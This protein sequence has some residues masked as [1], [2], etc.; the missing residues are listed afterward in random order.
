M[1]I[2]DRTNHHTT[3]IQEMFTRIAPRYDLIN[4]LMT[5]G[6]DQAWRKE[7]IRRADLPARGMLLDVGAGTGD[8]VRQAARQYA[9]CWPLAADL[10]LEMMRIGRERALASHENRIAW[11][12]VNAENLPLP[13]ASFDAVVSG[14][15]LRNVTH[16]DAALREQYRVLKPGGRLV[17]LDTTPPALSILTPLIRFHMHT[18]IPTLGRWLTGQSEAYHYLPD[19]SENFLPPE[20]LVARLVEVGFQEVGYHRRMFGTIAIYWGRKP[21]E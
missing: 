2:E 12:S 14:F 17:A 9:D 15:L 16:L 6:Q 13:A 3:R 10:T 5:F 8:L 11:L 19:S 18:V 21:A 1:L 4:R 7:V 20:Q